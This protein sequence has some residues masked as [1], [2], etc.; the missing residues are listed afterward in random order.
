LKGRTIK[1]IRLLRTAAAVTA[2]AVVV[3]AQQWQC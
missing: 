3:R 1:V 2:A